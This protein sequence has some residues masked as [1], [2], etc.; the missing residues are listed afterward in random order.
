VKYFLLW[1][2]LKKVTADMQTH[3]NPNLRAANVVP[4]KGT[5]Q[6]SAPTGGPASRIGADPNKAP[7][8]ELQNGKKWMVV[9]H[10]FFFS[11]LCVYSHMK[12]ARASR[13]GC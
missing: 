12:L 5:P 8:V 2:G 7:L 11:P 9:R 1:T 6:P 3:K 10:L 4:S 13:Q